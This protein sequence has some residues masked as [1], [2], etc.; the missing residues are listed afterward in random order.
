[1]S[2]V[3]AETIRSLIGQSKRDTVQE[4]PPAPVEESIDSSVDMSTIEDSGIIPSSPD[5][6]SS[7]ELPSSPDTVSQK[8]SFKEEVEPPR[9]LELEPWVWTNTLITSL[10]ALVKSRDVGIEGSIGWNLVEG[11]LVDTRIVDGREM[12]AA[13]LPGYEICEFHQAGI[14]DESV[15]P[16]EPRSTYQDIPTFNESTSFI[17]L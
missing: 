4:T 7:P 3:L 1:M 14:A 15:Y 11:D 13:I 5:I 16:R 12:T 8:P 17:I 6:T 2:E 9:I 10:K